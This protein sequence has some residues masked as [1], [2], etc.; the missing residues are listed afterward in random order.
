MSLKTRFAIFNVF[1]ILGCL[2]AGVDIAYDFATG[3][4]N[5]DL[6]IMIILAFVCLLIGVILRFTLVKCPT[7]VTVCWVRKTPPTSVPSAVHCQPKSRNG[8]G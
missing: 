4:T 6:P 1:I 5:Q 3:G 8:Y 7:A 2:F